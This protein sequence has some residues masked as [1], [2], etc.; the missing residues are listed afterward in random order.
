MVES[1]RLLRLTET[2]LADSLM[3]TFLEPPQAQTW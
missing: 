1:G 2:L 3:L